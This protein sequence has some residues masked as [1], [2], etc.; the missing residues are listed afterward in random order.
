MDLFSLAAKLTLDSSDY[1]KGIGNAEGML[2]KLGDGAK[3]IGIAM[4]ATLTAA[5]GAVAGLTK[6]ALDA[7]SDFEQLKGGVEKLFESSADAVMENAQKAFE[8]AGMS[9]N[10][11]METVTSFSAALIKSTGRGAQTD[12]EELKASLDEEYKATKRSLED[13]YK[14]REQYWNDRISMTKKKS[15]KEALK[16]ERDAE[17]KELKRQNEDTLAELKKHNKERVAAAEAA[18]SE[19][20]NSEESLARAAELADKAVVDMADNANTFGTDISEIQHAYAGF[21]KG[22]YTMLDNLKLGYGGTKEGME[23]LLKDAEKLTG[24]KYD[25]SNYADIVEA[26]HEVQTSLNI[27]GLSYEEAMDKYEKGELTYEE[28]L[29]AMGTT[30]RE[31]STTIEGSSKSMKAAWQNMLVA[32]ADPKGNTKKAT[33]NLVRTMKTF[34]KN[35]S[36]VI[37]QAISGIGD[38]LSEIAPMI[39]EELPG[40]IADI[41]P[42]LW[43]AGKKLISGLAKGVMTAIKKVKWPTWDDVKSA[44]SN[45]WKTIVNAVSN[46]GGLIFGQ[47]E[48]GTVKWPSW[49]DVKQG[50]ID[51]WNTI[52]EKLLTIGTWLGGLVFGKKADGSVNWPTWADVI[53][54]AIELWNTIKEKVKSIGSWL[55]GLVFGKRTDGKVNW[56][57]WATVRAKAIEVWEGIKEGAKKLK[58]LIFGD[59]ADAGNIFETISQKWKELRETIEQGAIKVATAFFG[60]ADPTTVAEAIKSIG[61]VLVSLGAGIFTFM[62]VSSFIKIVES[63]KTLLTLPSGSPIALIL[64]GIATAITL[65]A[66]NWDEIEPKIQEVGKWVDENLIQPFSSFFDDLKVWIANAINQIKRFLGLRVAG[67]LTKGEAEQL[68]ASY[69]QSKN[70]G[71]EEL[72]ESGWAEQLRQYLQKAGFEAEDVDRICDELVNS[73][74]PEWVVQFINDLTTAEGKAEALARLLNGE[75]GYEDNRTSGQY[76]NDYYSTHSHA[77]GDWSIPYDNYLA[78]LHRGEMVLTASQARQYREGGAD[79]NFN[80]LFSSIVSA[81]KEGLADATVNAYMDGKKVTR[82]SNRVNSNE[83]LAGRFRP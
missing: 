26:I 5:A 19:S 11:Y 40:I 30:A 65:I 52:K 8:T 69:Q 80:Q 55:G 15:A 81:V 39:G 64:A 59:A 45:A 66:Q 31:A 18:N 12:T 54:G 76:Y 37:T 29:K 74:K 77:K 32:F 62:A 44:I 6:Q 83:L 21:A 56:P 68:T 20:Q 72:I 58:G 1:T 16:K 82:E 7:Y 27:S 35:V 48:D 46:L 73:N 41:V 42:K 25:M 43:D 75:H 33:K 50:A 34:Y 23:Q 14:E 4:G 17:L 28:A 51:L 67:E 38:F 57:T 78:N 24:K 70:G 22:N 3:K 61:D 71:R 63:I 60:D 79:I 13:Q 9:A 49:D 47:N 10:Q 53:A 2:S 36:P